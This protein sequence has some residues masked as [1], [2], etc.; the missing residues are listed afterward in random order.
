MIRVDIEY[1]RV[2]QIAKG[3]GTWTNIHVIAQLKKAGIP[4]D[5]GVDL[6]GVLHGRLTMFNEYRAGKRFCVYEWVEGPDSHNAAF[7]DDDEI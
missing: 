3:H 7:N 5:G 2:V 4:V 1:E 6:R